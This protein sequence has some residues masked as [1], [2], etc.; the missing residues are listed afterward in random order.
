MI[1]TYYML[2]AVLYNI[3]FIIHSSYLILLHHVLVGGAVLNSHRFH[4]DLLSS[5]RW[6]FIRHVYLLC[7][8]VICNNKRERQDN[9]TRKLSNKYFCRD[10]G[11][12]LVIFVYCRV[13][14][15]ARHSYDECSSVCHVFSIFHHLRKIFTGLIYFTLTSIFR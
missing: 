7:K 3:Q 11:P 12:K 9:L 13:F 10:H 8:T 15:K 14:I 6:A 5:G 1:A 4:L 2:H